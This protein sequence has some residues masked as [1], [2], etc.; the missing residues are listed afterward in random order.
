[1]NIVKGINPKTKKKETFRF[2]N[3]DEGFEQAKKKQ[4]E[5]I[6]K[7]YKNTFHEASTIL[8][9]IFFKQGEY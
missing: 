7:G 6:K 4:K 3:N 1:M 5:L 8:G 9:N 2:N